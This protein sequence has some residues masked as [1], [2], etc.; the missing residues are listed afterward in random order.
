MKYLNLAVMS[1]CS[2]NFVYGQVLNPGARFA[3][4]GN[5][6]VAL[7][8]VWSLQANQAGLAALKKTEAGAAYQS[9]I[10]NTGISTQT[11]LVAIPL[12]GSVFGVSAQ[13]Y[14]I[15]E[16]R[17]QRFGFT[18][19]R[20]FGE[21]IFASLNFNLHQ[22][23]I[24]QYG[25]AGTWSADAGIQYRVKGSLLIGVHVSNLN[26]NGF[27]ENVNTSIPEILELGASLELSDKVLLTGAVMKELG[28]VSGLKTGM[29]Y[30]LL[31]QLF[32]RG[33]VTTNPFSHYAGLGYRYQAFKIDFAVSS[34]PD[35]GYSSQLSISYEF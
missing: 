27:A 19:S 30:A 20:S 16:F 32:L 14:G 1:I 3:S 26:H 33:G 11:L 7:Q 23:R 31:D 28:S 24:V 10:M 12:K 21:T 8:D 25:N 29:E 13:S 22:Q 17:Q 6:G 15:P 5:A 4:M 18:Y 34:H 35:L 2:V 9:N